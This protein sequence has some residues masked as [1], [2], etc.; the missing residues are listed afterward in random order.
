MSRQ[1]CVSCNPQMQLHLCHLLHVRSVIYT[2][3]AH[4]YTVPTKHYEHVMP[5]WY[6]LGLMFILK[7]TSGEGFIQN[8]SL[9]EWNSPQGRMLWSIFC[10][11]S[12]NIWIH[13]R[14]K[15]AHFCTLKIF[16]WLYFSHSLCRRKLSKVIIT[17]G[18]YHV[19]V[20]FTLVQTS[21]QGFPN[22]CPSALIFTNIYASLCG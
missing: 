21:F 5:L 16:I 13:A 2:L 22:V 9:V 11:V 6:P 18:C 7:L 15:Y 10:F 4:A 17:L 3:T 8:H 1:M 19:S 20:K 12:M 14:H